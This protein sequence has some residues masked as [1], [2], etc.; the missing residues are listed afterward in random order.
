VRIVAEVPESGVASFMQ[1][2]R[3]QKS[4]LMGK[5]RELGVKAVLTKYPDVAASMEGWSRIA[6]TRYFL[7]ASPASAPRL[8]EAR[9]TQ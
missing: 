1:A 6:G 2:G 3:E 5:F 9:S 7:W 8:S 4:Q